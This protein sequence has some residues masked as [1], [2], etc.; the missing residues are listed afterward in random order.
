MSRR[1]TKALAIEKIWMMIENPLDDD[2]DVDS[3]DVIIA[4]LGISYGLCVVPP[5]TVTTL[6]CIA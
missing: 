5:A 1:R 4:R 6:I 2:D 3:G